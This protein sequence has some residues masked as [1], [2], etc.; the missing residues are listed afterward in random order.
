MIFSRALRASPKAQS[1]PG[2]SRTILSLDDLLK[3][4]SDDSAGIG[5]AMQLSPI[6]AAHRILT[7][8]MGALPIALH[9]KTGEKRES[10]TEHRT[11]YPLTVRANPDMSPMIF[12]KIMMSQ[13]FWYGETF[14]CGVDRAPGVY[15]MELLPLPQPSLRMRDRGGNLW[16]AFEVN[17][18]SRKLSEPEL[19]HNFFDTS[20]AKSGLGILDIARQTVKIDRASQR[21]AGNFYSHGARPSGIVEVDSEMGPEQKEIVRNAFERMVGGVD[22][23]FRTAVLD[24]G[25]KYTPLGISQRDAQYVESRN[26]NVEEV[27]RFTGVPLP[28]LQA[29]K[30]TYN[31]NEAQGIDYVVST[32]QP[33][34]VQWEQEYA[35]KL[36]TADEL[37]SGMYYRFNLAAEMRGD[38]KSRADFLVAMIRGGIYK[39]NEARAFEEKDADPD[40]D[41]LMASKDLAP[42]RDIVSG[43]VS[44]NATGGTE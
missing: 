19:I 20:D 5:S 11:L 31:T 43:A 14:A 38:N 3:G 18:V 6:A 44:G 39:P 2:G 9:K 22:N 26:F 32:L 29:G 37:N 35:Y 23:A 30:Q 24:Q 13:A 1:P 16:Y 40:G 27:A 8:S 34:A 17:G 21:F 4:W 33:Q 7:N 10:I 25:M 12:R 42:L 28:K 36:L 41:T 15:P